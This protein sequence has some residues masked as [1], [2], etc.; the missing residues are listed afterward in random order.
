[1]DHW[2]I[3]TFFA[4]ATTAAEYTPKISDNLF[5]W[6]NFIEADTYRDYGE[7][8]SIPVLFSGNKNALYPWRQKIVRLVSKHYPS[9]MCPHLG[10][11]LHNSEMQVMV[12]E[13][14]ARMLNA[15]AFVP[16][17]GTVAKEVVRKHFEIPA[18]KACLI[19]EQSAGLEAAGFCRY[20]ELRLRR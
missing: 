11:A 18:C 6:P 12:G 14:Y 19:T 13:P 5:I 15:S 8:K 20:E 16:A 9:L 10:T 7:Y 2:G 1:M 3:G 17:C 4:I